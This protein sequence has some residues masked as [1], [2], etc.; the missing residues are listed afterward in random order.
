MKLLVVF[1]S[2]SDHRTFGPL[3]EKL[4]SKHEV[5]F[6]VMSAHRNAQGLKELLKK[7]SDVQAVIAGA[8]LAAHLPGVV[9]SQVNC[10]VFGLPVDSIF[11]GLDAFLSIVQ[12]PRGVPVLASSPGDFLSI[13][14]YLDH[15]RLGK[16]QEKVVVYMA[17]YLMNYEFALV[18][19]AKARQKASDLGLELEVVHEPAREDVRI[20]L[21]VDVKEAALN[22]PKDVIKVPL[23]DPSQKSDAQS[24]VS[25]LTM[26]RRGGLW[27]GANNVTNALLFYTQC[28]KFF[29]SQKLDNS[30]ITSANIQEV[31]Q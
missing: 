17:S 26:A 13:S 15:F 8:G 31:S 25:F 14:N 27:V 3:V 16:K 28:C 1:G 20:A 22:W 7:N 4:K 12:M 30:K 23:M 10:P 6:E 11:Q 21:L 24:G 18:E 29:S 2:Q 19:L 5:R 9:A